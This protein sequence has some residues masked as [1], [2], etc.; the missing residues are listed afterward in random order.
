M[1]EAQAAVLFGGGCTFFQ[2]LPFVHGTEMPG[3]VG[4]TRLSLWFLNG[5][6]GQGFPAFVGA[7]LL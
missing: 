3:C 4:G 6:M 5:P 2:V 7:L 1:R